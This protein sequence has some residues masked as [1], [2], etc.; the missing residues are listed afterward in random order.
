MLNTKPNAGLPRP[1]AGDQ[2]K[3]A[4]VPSAKP[5]RTKTSLRG[6]GTALIAGVGVFVIG[7]G[8]FF[9]ALQGLQPDMVEVYRTSNPLAVN[10]ML[11]QADIEIA[12]VNASELSPEMLTREDL[13]S[14]LWFAKVS[15]PAG[16]P[17]T[18]VLLDTSTRTNVELPAGMVLASF[19][20]D[21]ASAVAGKVQAGDYIN[22]TA[23]GQ[24]SGSNSQV[25]RVILNRVLV[26]DANVGA[27]SQTQTAGQTVD[28]NEL[29]GSES[30]SVYGGVPTLYT[31][32]VTNEQAATL[33][34]ARNM[35]L[36]V[37]LTS[38]DATGPVDV[39]VTDSEVFGSGPVTAGDLTV[40]TPGDGTEEQVVVEQASPAPADTDAVV[41]E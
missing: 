34:L 2:G 36:Y 4:K 3:P 28:A 32:A 35:D 13:D 7:A 39:S 23:V 33:A 24:V 27:K 17:L 19:E 9:I 11:T 41:P 6:K 30:P 25:A 20:A 29:P 16:T 37:T 38:A 40:A 22:I 31:V 21:P 18:R 14:R 10:Q 15:L 5:V 12:E 8:G 26:L 1:D